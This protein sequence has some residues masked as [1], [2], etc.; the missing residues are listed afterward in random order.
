MNKPL[1]PDLPNQ[2]LAKHLFMNFGMITLKQNMKTEQNYVTWMLT[3][4]L[5]IL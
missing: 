5:F 1:Y 3:A 4:L 2:I